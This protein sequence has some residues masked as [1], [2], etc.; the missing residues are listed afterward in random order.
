MT[1]SAIA[2]S[3]LNPLTA[4]ITL[5]SHSKLMPY[6]NLVPGSNSIGALKIAVRPESMFGTP[7]AASHLTSSGL[8]NQ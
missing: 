6:S 7:V 8:K 2:S 3:S 5:P 4:S 1:T